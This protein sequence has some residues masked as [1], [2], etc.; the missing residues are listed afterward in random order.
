MEN[1]IH[2]KVV[3]IRDPHQRRVEHKYLNKMFN[4]T[5]QQLHQPKVNYKYQQHMPKNESGTFMTNNQF[6]YD[7]KGPN[8]QILN[9]HIRSQPDFS[10]LRIKNPVIPTQNPRQ[11]EEAIRNMNNPNIMQMRHN[12][13]NK[14]YGYENS[15]QYQKGSS[16]NKSFENLP[17]YFRTTII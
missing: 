8:N 9:Q 17:K 1:V 16:L 15:Q 10:P 7:Q 2:S 13:F 12:T 11:V 6:Y 5:P 3:G 4:Q 14:A